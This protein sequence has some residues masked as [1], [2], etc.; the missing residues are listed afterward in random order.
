M[1]RPD[2]NLALPKQGAPAPRHNFRRLDQRRTF[3]PAQAAL[4][5]ALIAL[6]GGGVVAFNIM[7]VS[8]PRSP[9]EPPGI[10]QAFAQ[11]RDG[12]VSLASASADALGLEDAM[13]AEPRPPLFEPAP[14][15]GGHVGIEP[16][17]ARSVRRNA[18][19]TIARP[20]PA[21]EAPVLIPDT[22]LAELERSE[23]AGKP[24]S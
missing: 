18:R 1:L 4:A 9:V 16:P 12:A 13:P 11:Q 8:T 22:I 6:V 3:S 7:P 19:R 21:F 17:S 14:Q 24:R 20:Q 15:F 5:F 10:E 2:Q 23:H